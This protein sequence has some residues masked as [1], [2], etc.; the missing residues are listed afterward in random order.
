MV[1]QFTA[2]LNLQPG[3]PGGHF[4]NSLPISFLSM[5]GSLALCSSLSH[6][7]TPRPDTVPW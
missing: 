2:Q 3:R 5:V 6:R 7:I 1:A 4:V